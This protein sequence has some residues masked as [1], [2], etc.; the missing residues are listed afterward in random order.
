MAGNSLLGALSKIHMLNAVALVVS[1]SAIQITATSIPVGASG[2]FISNG[3]T[4]GG[5]YP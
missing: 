1:T 2:A 3:F 4:G 5:P